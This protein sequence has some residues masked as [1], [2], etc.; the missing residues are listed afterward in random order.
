MVHKNQ[1]GRG[2][3]QSSGTHLTWDEV[4]HFILNP[5]SLGVPLHRQNRKRLLSKAS[6]ATT[7]VRGFPIER[8][9]GYMQM[10]FIRTK[11]L[12]E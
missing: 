8:N 3:H 2:N 12:V 4:D 7:V 9:V 6:T 11:R 10:K 5:K 1:I